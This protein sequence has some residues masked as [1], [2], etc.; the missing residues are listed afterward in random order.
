MNSVN[1]VASIDATDQLVDVDRANR[2]LVGVR[3]SGRRDGE[4]FHRCAVHGVFY[5]ALT[6]RVRSYRARCRVAHIGHL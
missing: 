6:R 2:V 4:T 3:A 1:A 5:G